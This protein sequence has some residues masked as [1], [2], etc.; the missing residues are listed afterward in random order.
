[1]DNLE[2]KSLSRALGAFLRRFSRGIKTAPSRRHFRTYIRGQLSDLERKTVA[3]IAEGAGVVKRSLQEFL[4]I[5]RWDQKWM[6]DRVQQIVATEHADEQAI[7]VIDETSYAKR[8]VSTAGVLEFP[9]FC[10]QVVKQLCA[11]IPQGCNSP[12]M[13]ATSLDY[14]TPRCIRISSFSP[15]L[16]L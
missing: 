8:G 7:G 4:E 10:R 9:R 3:A 16:G 14:R 6:R 2:L 11:H 1:M 15:P 12:G 5:H 13:S